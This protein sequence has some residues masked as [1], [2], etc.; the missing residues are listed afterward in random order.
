MINY[1][2]IKLMILYIYSIYNRSD[3]NYILLIENNGYKN[4]ANTRER[5]N[6]FR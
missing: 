6:S 2:D 5:N 1:S 3:S 4:R